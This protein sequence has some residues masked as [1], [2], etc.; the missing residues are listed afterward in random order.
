MKYIILQLNHMLRSLLKILYITQVGTV[1]VVSLLEAIK[2]S[3]KD[4]KFYQASSSEMFGGID[5]NY[6][7]RNLNFFQ[8]A[9]MLFPKYLLMI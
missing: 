6:S 2:N 3:K 8:R 1:G 4:I 9:P 7:L 5:N